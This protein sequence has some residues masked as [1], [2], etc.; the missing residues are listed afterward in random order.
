MTQTLSDNS[1]KNS[2]KDVKTCTIKPK[3]IL[4]KDN[5][6]SNIDLYLI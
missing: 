4:F 1:R 5:V 6:Y 3:V 2:D